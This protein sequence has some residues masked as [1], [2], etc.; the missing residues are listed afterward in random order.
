MAKARWYLLISVEILNIFSDIHTFLMQEMAIMTPF[1]YNSNLLEL[2][3][4]IS[5]IFMEDYTKLLETA[6]IN[7]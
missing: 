4:F 5:V 6:T 3:V 1:V 7:P 2:F